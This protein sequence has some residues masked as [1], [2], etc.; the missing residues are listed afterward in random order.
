MMIGCLQFNTIFCS[1]NDN[2]NILV[3]YY[4]KGVG[5]NPLPFLGVIE[6]DFKKSIL[7]IHYDKNQVIIKTNS[8]KLNATVFEEFVQDGFNEIK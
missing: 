6:Q 5:F 1:Q 4:K 7:L 3:W 8:L 2:H